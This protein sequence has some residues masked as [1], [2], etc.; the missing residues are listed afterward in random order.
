M[1][2]PST[3]ELIVEYGG[4]AIAAQRTRRSLDELLRMSPADGLIAGLGTVNAALMGE[5]R[6]AAMVIAYD[7][8]VLAGTQG[9]MNH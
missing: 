5:A 2:T 6:A 9:K 8:T 4:L 7:H 3:V 1:T